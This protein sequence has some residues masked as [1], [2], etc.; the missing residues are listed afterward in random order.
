MNNF[1]RLVI[2]GCGDLAKELINWMIHSELYENI[3][4]RLFFIDDIQNKNFYVNNLEI[5]YLGKI[6][7]VSLDK[8]D[9]FYLGISDPKVK[10]R[11]VNQL[12]EKKAYFESFIHPSAIVSPSSKIG[13][14]CIIFPYSVCSNNSQLKDF[15]TLNTHSAV[16]HD[17]FVDSYCTIS[18]MVDLTG[19]VVLGKRVLVGSGARFLPKVQIG[20]DS[21]VGAGAIVYRSIPKG[22]TIYSRPSKIL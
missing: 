14:G 16:G 19:N 13:K 9:K 21:I 11:V 8:K 20:E 5:I 3:G 6:C 15:I 2:I 1:E 10:F 4:E 22:K 7:N 18:S 12:T 17:A